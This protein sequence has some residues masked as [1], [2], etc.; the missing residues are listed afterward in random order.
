MVKTYQ[1]NLINNKNDITS[2]IQRQEGNNEIIYNICKN[3]LKKFKNIKSPFNKEKINTNNYQKVYF[4]LDF[5]EIIN[6]KKELFNKI[7]KIKLLFDVKSFFVYI[8]NYKSSNEKDV[9]DILQSLKIHF[10]KTK[11]EKIDYIY[12]KTCEY[13][14]NEFATR[15]ICQFENNKCIAK[16][17]CDLTCGCCRH[18]KDRNFFSLLASEYVECEYLKNKHCSANCISCKLYTCPTLNKMGIKFRIKDLFLLNNYF[19]IRQRIIVKT[20][21]FTPKEIIIRKLV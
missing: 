4:V 14:D 19:S 20:Y 21:C 15:N 13:L 7:K 3:P 1:I 11:L 12:D 6:E 18:S 16:R 2:N 10:L 8:Q 5:N 9:I 17:E